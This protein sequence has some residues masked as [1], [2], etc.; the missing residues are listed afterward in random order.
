[1]DAYS[2]IIISLILSAFFSGMEI[3]F[4]SSNKLRMELDRK[5]NGVSSRLIDFFYRHSEQYISTMLVGNNI[6]LVI[7]GIK[8]AEL[9]DPVFASFIHNNFAVSLMQTICATI[10]VLITGE[11]LPKTIF[12]ANPNLWL[13][14]FAPVLAV[15]YV[16]LYPIT[17]LA[18]F[19]SRLI[20]SIFKAYS[21]K[22]GQQSL[23]KADLD[24]LI[25]ETLESHESDVEIEN[26]VKL[27]QNALDFSSVKIRDCIVPRTEIIALPEEGTTL[28]DLKNTFVSTGYSK[29]LIYRDTI[30]NIIGYFHAANIFKQP[31]NWRELLLKM[32]IVPETMAANKLMDIFMQE[33]KSIAVVVDEFGGT[34]GIVTL[35]D[36]M[37]EIFGEIEDEH[38]NREYTA[39]QINEH[40]YV[41]SG[42]LEID[43]ANSQ[44]ELGI[45]ESDNYITVAG[46]I[47]YHYQKFPKL[48]ETIR[49]DNFTFKVLAA[50]NN[51]I[52]LVK[53]TK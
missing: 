19:L 9:L 26:D 43:A 47:L 31:D 52:D 49:I 12:K 32:P 21:P 33:K 22:S 40:E 27:F 51:R 4:V 39:K 8:M 5:N 6:V 1:M 42:R 25:N 2:I 7:Y 24:Y 10:I 37:E 20:L 28:D 23:N 53:L 48:N 36:I 15:F 44:F 41:L 14:I 35:E 34:A 50:H 17:I 13:R 30:D 16:I 29:I 38:D 11:F 46:Y 45:P 18:T 3:A